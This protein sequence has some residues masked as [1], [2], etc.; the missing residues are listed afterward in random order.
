MQEHQAYLS[1]ANLSLAN[2]DGKNNIFEAIGYTSI[3]KDKNVPGAE[4]FLNNLMPL[5]E[6]SEIDGLELLISSMESEISK[7]IITE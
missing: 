6:S 7:L 1:L 5:L 3:A 2:A 4:E